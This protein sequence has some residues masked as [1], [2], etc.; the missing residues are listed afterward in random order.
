MQRNNYVGVLFWIVALAALVASGCTPG[1]PTGDYLETQG[2]VPNGFISSLKTT[3]PVIKGTMTAPSGWCDDVV[4]NVLGQ[5]DDQSPAPIQFITSFNEGESC[6]WVDP[7]CYA[8]A[9]VSQAQDGSIL[10]GGWTDC[11]LPPEVP[12]QQGPATLTLIP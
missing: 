2:Q 6:A 9:D 4:L 3:G 7:M 12:A 10:T 5:I 1:I 8:L 11:T